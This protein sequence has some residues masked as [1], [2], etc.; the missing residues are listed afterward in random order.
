MD[1]TEQTKIANGA[2][3]GALTFGIS[4]LRY[5]TIYAAAT[6]V[7][8]GGLYYNNIDNIGYIY[9]GEQKSEW[10]RHL[11]DTSETEEQRA[12][13]LHHQ[14]VLDWN[15][16]PANYACKTG[17]PIIDDMFGDKNCQGPL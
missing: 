14:A 6:G 7:L 16:D 13:R 2:I 15:S 5:D 8:V 3:L 1:K 4:S 12:A 11:E 9:T 10:Q 17:N